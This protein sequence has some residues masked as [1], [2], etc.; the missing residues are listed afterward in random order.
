ML[1]DL[2]FSRLLEGSIDESDLGW[3]LCFIGD[4]QQTKL[5]ELVGELKGKFSNAGDGKRISSGF[6]Y[7]GIGPTISWA[8]TCADPF[9][10]V[11]KESIRSFRSRWR[12]I[13]SKRE[14]NREFH[15]VSLGVGTGEKDQHILKTLLDTQP[16][17]LYF[18]V[19][20]S[21][22]M[23]R[24]A[25]QEVTK[26]E[27]LKGSQILP[28]QIDF[29]DRKRGENLRNLLDQVVPDHPILFSL[30]GNTLANFQLDAE[31]LKI[32]SKLMREND[33]L[34]IEVASTKDLDTQTVQEAKE[35]YEKIESFKK[36]ATSALLQNTDLHIDLGNVLFQPTLEQD[37]AILIKV[38]YQNR[39]GE[40]I[41]VMLPDWSFTE[42]S[43]EDTIQL[44]LT[45]KYTPQ[46]I[47]K[48]ILENN[49]SIVDRRTTDF[50]RQYN[51][52]FGMDLIL[53][54]P[55]L[56][57]NKDNEGSSLADSVWKPSGSKAVLKKG[58]D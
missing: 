22:T 32:I 21:S 33:L 35:E 30:L 49:L 41:Q 43:S 10:P 56:A 15:Y 38:I 6:S 47:E 9:Y 57:G 50:E 8:K 27:N 26:I 36:F 20:M 1:S 37:K 19:D 11:M 2:T 12:D 51:T 34:L 52:K 39:T 29:S 53:V 44:H 48:M 40:M 45:R 14:K 28:I 31:L 5:A 7:W 42:F 23:L 3:T 55:C 54:A 16:N 24:M 58:V 4:S 13:Y 18:P 25:I 17:L 46:G